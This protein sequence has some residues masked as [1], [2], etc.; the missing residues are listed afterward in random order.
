[1]ANLSSPYNSGRLTSSREELEEGVSPPPSFAPTLQC[2]SCPRQFSQPSLLERHMRSH[3][4]DRPHQCKI[5][6]RSYTQ[7]GNLNVHMKTVH[8]VLEPA[9]ARVGG[10]VHLESSRP[11]KC[12]ICNRLFTT[13]SNMYQHIRVSRSSNQSQF[14]HLSFPSGC[15]QHA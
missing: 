3:S 10:G 8:G 6:G 1:M 9:G 2:P 15:S 7:S 11:H 14:S 4:Q 5:C 12:Y 13:T